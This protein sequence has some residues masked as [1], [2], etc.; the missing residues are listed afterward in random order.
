[1][2]DI[3]YITDFSNGIFE[4]TLGDNPTAVTGNRALMNR[5]EVTFM[6]KTRSFIYR[7]QLL[8]DNYGGNAPTFVDQPQVLENTQGIATAIAAAIDLTVQSIL[9]DQPV[10]IPDTEKLSSAELISLDAV[11]DMIGAT[12]EIHPVQYETSEALR[13]NLPITKR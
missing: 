7:N 10:N 1:M 11:D 9:N 4:I 5:F 12:I 6:T 8:M 3:D 13:L 2:A